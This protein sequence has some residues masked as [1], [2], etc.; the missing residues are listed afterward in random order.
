MSDILL[1]VLGLLETAEAKERKATKRAVKASKE[2]KKPE[3]LDEAFDRVLASKLKEDERCIVLEIK[4]LL[5]TAQIARADETKKLSKK[6]VFQLWDQY[7]LD[8]REKLK[9]HVIDTK[10]DNFWVVQDIITLGKV[11]EM[12]RTEPVTAWD[13]ETTGLDIFNDKVIGYSIYLPGHD[14][15]VYISWGHEVDDPQCPE[16]IALN[17]ARWYLGN[18]N[19]KT[20]W[21]NYAFDGHMFLNHGVS[22]ANPYW[23]SCIVS[24]ILNEKEQN[25]KLKSLYDKYVLK[26]VDTSPQFGDLFDDFKIYDKPVVLSGIY[27]AGDAYKTYKLFSFQKPYID[28]VDNLRT[29]WYVIEQ[30][31]MEVD[32]AME[33][34]GFRIDL[35]RIEQLKVELQPRLSLAEK[36]I[37]AAFNI[38]E[39]FLRVMS[40]ALGRTETV[41]N[42][43]SP[44]HLSYLIYD[45]LGVDEDFGKR[46]GKASRTTA[47]D[48][49]DA[50]CADHEELAP[51]LEYRKLTKIVSTYL[52]KIPKAMEPATGRLHSRFNNMASETGMSTGTETGRYS[53]STYVSGKNSRTGSDAKGT[54][55][56]NIPGRGFGK[57]V[58]KCFI[59]DDDWILI[60]CDLSQIEPRVIAAILAQQYNDRSMLQ[61]YL[62]GKDLY[63]QMAM[64][65]FGFPA[66]NCVDKAY[67]PD[68]SF[69]P[70]SLMKT[71]VLSYL[72][73]SSSKSFARTMKVSEEVAANF[74]EKM[75]VAFPGLEA[76][77]ADVLH[78]LLHRGP[79]AFASTLFGR[80]RRFPDYRKNYVELQKL[81]KMKPWTMTAEQKAR[82]SKLWG[83]CAS[84]ERQALNHTVQGSA[85]DILKQNMVEMYKFVKA[86]NYK[87]H[88][89]IHDELIPSV[90]LKD[91]TPELV[92][93]IRSIMCDT[94]DIGV[95]LKTDIAIMP[96]WSEEYSPEQWDYQKHMP[97][98][99]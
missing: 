36:N 74:F 44:Q 14:I 54:N 6:E 87:L 8:K 57:E 49:V 52:E 29:V 82:R 38:D 24:K 17:V 77:R 7:R 9:Q 18:P 65:A 94:V 83:L 95:P 11:R 4:R 5:E 64:F 34:T 22:V 78:K 16:D 66:E 10:P 96:R 45:V 62:D 91:L 51:L 39:T 1:D 47:A 28:T 23:D 98:A 33:R 75:I 90:P 85:A 93:K 55:L 56:Q 2:K 61:F 19:N 41:F 76:F 60:S 69:Q 20:I 80:K 40:S 63:Q 58:R 32:L 88:A 53:S 84:V 46:F 37:I 86:N 50:L 3:S 68:G 70:R 27:A 30:P 42:V 25:H 81:N 48:V 31:L 26:A 21:H 35:D 79:I 15:A 12:L 59:P 97:L 43:N 67:S 89:S 92:E 73:G 71:G 13:T 99:A 72:Y